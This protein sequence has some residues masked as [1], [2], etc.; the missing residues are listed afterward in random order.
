MLPMPV[1]IKFSKLGNLKYISHLDLQRTMKSTLLRARLPIAYTE[2]FN[3]HPKLAFALPLS[4]G[5]ESVCECLDLKLTREL[6]Y[7]EIRERLDR[8][9][10]DNLSILEAY[11]PKHKI[12]EIAWAEYRVTTDDEYSTDML[13]RDEI[14]IM[15]RTKRGGEKEVDIRPQIKDITFNGRDISMIVSASP[16]SFLNPE[17][18]IKLLGLTD[19]TLT[20]TQIMLADGTPFR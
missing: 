4:I 19:Y 6:P 18:V 15:K 13:S 3:P 11:E 8:A 16:D 14:L 12:G 7:D 5:A 20:R 1:R 17:Y 2:G 9:T 10:V